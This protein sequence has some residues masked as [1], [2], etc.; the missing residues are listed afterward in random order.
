MANTSDLLVKPLNNP[1]SLIQIEDD[2]SR[3][4]VSPHLNPVKALALLLLAFGPTD[5]FS[6][7]SGRIGQ[8]SSVRMSATT[9]YERLAETCLV[10]GCPD[11]MVEELI[12]DLGVQNK[13]HPDPQVVDKIERLQKLLDEAE[14]ERSG[15][16][17]LVKRV[18]RGENFVLLP[19]AKQ[20]ANDCIG[21]GCPTYSVEELIDELKVEENP[22]E[23]V[24]SAIEK[25]EGVVKRTKQRQSD[26]EFLVADIAKAKPTFGSK[27]TQDHQ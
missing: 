15:I 3:G 27:R 14:T 24:R 10:H 19:K 5:A 2:V 21:E 8:A 16:K 23:H 4:S 7:A 17:K 13:Q 11:S 25:F 6:P 9:G 18:A 22:N 20:A 1:Q 26:I 12:F